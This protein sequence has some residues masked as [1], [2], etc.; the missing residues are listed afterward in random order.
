MP[1]TTAP[2]KPHV[3]TFRIDPRMKADLEELAER[4][5]RPVGEVLRELVREHVDRQRRREF[6]AE[7]HRQ[8]LELAAAAR[9]PDS[10]EAAMLRQLDVLFDELAA[11]EDRE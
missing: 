1:R 2:A 3:V 8:S 11:A 4:E 5:S 6:E 10:D 7:A 9:D